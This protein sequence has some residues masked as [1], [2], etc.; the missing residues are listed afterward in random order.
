MARTDLRIV[1]T[2]EALHHALLELLNEK[3]LEDISIS[4]ICRKAKI[5][6]GTFYLHYNQ[7][8]DLFE[9]YFK[10]I[11]A[12]LARS[13]QEPYRH[14]SVLKTSELEPSTIRIFHHIEKYKLFYRIIFSKKVPL[15]YYY[16]L[17]E[18]I[19]HL[20][21]QDKEAFPKEEVNR[22]LYCSYQANAIIGMI[23]YWYQNDFSYSPSYLNHQLVQFLNMKSNN[24]SPW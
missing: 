1:K 12:D 17:F 18:E 20:L 5:N 15:M 13:Y 10:E 11:T 23:I 6:R 4:E 24:E 22:Q 14:V 16:L 8:E 7:I 9:E 2:K 19:N 21:L 3:A